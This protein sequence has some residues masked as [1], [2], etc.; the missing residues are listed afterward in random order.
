MQGYNRKGFAYKYY[1]KNMHLHKTFG[2]NYDTIFCQG[3]Y[4]YENLFEIEPCSAFDI[5]TS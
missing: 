4:M 1:S 5:I 3:K 2:P